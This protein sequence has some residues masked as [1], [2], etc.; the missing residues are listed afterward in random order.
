MQSKIDEIAKYHGNEQKAFVLKELGDLSR[1]RV[2][3]NRVLVVTYITPS[4]SRGGILFTPAQ[5]EESIYQGKVG[6]I[7]KKGPL[8]YVDDETTKFGG[9]NPDVGAWVFFRPS[10]AIMQLRYDGIDCRM[11]ADEQ[12][13][14]D[15]QEPEKMW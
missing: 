10:L 2:Y 15:L 8:A 5:T 4:I 7:I 11:F 14:G 3:G 1:F 12:I 13:G 9:M 6:Y